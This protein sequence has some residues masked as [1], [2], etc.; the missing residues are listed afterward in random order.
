VALVM[1]LVFAA[2]RVVPG[3]PAVLVLGEQASDADLAEFR[4]ATWLDRP[5]HQQLGRYLASVADGSLG[6]PYA[7]YFAAPTVGALVWDRLPYTIELAFAALAV[8]AAVALPFGLWSGFWPGS[9]LDRG[10]LAFS[11]VGVAVPTFW[12]GPMLLYAFAVGLRVLPG[13][14]EPISGPAHLILPAATLGLAMAGKLLR[15][16]R[17]GV[18]EVRGEDYVL[19]ARGKGVG[20]LRLAVWHVLPGALVPVITLMGVQLASL[21]GGTIIVEQVFARPGVGRLLMEAVLARDYNVVQGC[22]LTIAVGYVLV[23][24]VVDLLYARVDPRVRVQG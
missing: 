10:V 16:V 19:V 5:I 21:L 23:H 13:P 9:L 12:F 7:A 24:L 11:L 17:A 15:F 14:A 22:V 3:D 1:L 18:L 6:R 2:L 20:G 4:R 8:A